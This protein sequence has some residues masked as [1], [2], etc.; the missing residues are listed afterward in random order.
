MKLAD[1]AKAAEKK[2]GPITVPIEDENGKILVEFSKMLRLSDEQKKA[3]DKIDADFRDAEESSNFD[4]T[5]RMRRYLVVV[6]NDKT[7][8]KKILA[9]MDDA[10]VLYL[11][12]QVGT[13]S[14]ESESGKS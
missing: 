2:F 11:M 14:D 10:T 13:G 7:E 3:I 8:A 4:D 5:D 6:A 12:D 1:I 9:G